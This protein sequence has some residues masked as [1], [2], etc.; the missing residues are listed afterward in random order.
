MNISIQPIKKLN[1]HSRIYIQNQQ[2]R[3]FCRQILPKFHRTNVCFLMPLKNRWV[4]SYTNCSRAVNLK[5][6]FTLQ[7]PGEQF[8]ILMPGSTSRDW[9]IWHGPKNTEHY[10]IN[11][12][13]PKSPENSPSNPN[14]HLGITELV[15]KIINR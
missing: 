2:A 7:S 5:P 11:K 14:V 15:N 6:G 12:Q 9:F 4:L 1:K 8:K 3:Q 10:F 13:K